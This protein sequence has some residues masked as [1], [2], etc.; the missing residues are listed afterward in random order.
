LY[1]MCKRAGW[2]DI[3]MGMET[4]KK[5]EYKNELQGPTQLLD[6]SNP[7]A[8]NFADERFVKTFTTHQTGGT[9][10]TAQIPASLGDTTYMPGKKEIDSHQKS[11]LFETT[12]SRIHL[13]TQMTTLLP[14]SH[15]SL[16]I[17]LRRIY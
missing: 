11:D 10:Y 1:K 13:A 9:N 15:S 4:F 12:L 2:V 6:P 3:T 16:T 7:L 14:T 5:I 8:L 17:L